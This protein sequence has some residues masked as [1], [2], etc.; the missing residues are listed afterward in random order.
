VH[1]KLVV[2]RMLKDADAIYGIRHVALRYLNEAG[3]H[4]NGGFGELHQP[5]RNYS[6][7][8]GTSI[9]DYAHVSDLA[10]RLAGGR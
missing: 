5:E 8:V 7:P 4:P 1:T 9:L 2:E 3:A 10:G 6:T